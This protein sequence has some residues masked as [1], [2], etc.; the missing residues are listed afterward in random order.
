MLNH[1]P[2]VFIIL[3]RNARDLLL[4]LR[5]L[6]GYI[7]LMLDYVIRLGWPSD[8]I[9]DDGDGPNGSRGDQTGAAQP[10]VGALHSLQTHRF[11]KE[12]AELPLEGK[13]QQLE[14]LELMEVP[15]KKKLFKL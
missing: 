2:N 12:A 6:A 4:N 10:K 11:S 5:C 7:D 14:G 1:N 15:K 13:S 8:L 9:A 3:E